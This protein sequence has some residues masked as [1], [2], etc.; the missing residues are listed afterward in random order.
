[1]LRRLVLA[2]A[3]AFLTLASA[4]AQVGGPLC[5]GGGT[6]PD[7]KIQGGSGSPVTVT[8]TGTA[9]TPA[10]GIITVQGNPS[11]TPVPVSGTFSAT[12]GGFDPTAVGTPI[13]A[14]TGGATGTLPSGAVV[15]ATNVG[16]TNGAFCALGASS[17]TSWQYIAPGGGWFAFTVGAATQLTCLTSASTTTINMVGGAGLATG[18]SGGGGS[19]SGAVT[20]NS[21]PSLANGNG[22]VPTQGGTV[23]SA[24]NGMYVNLLQGNAVLSSGNPIFASITNIPAVTQSGGPWTFNQTQLDSVNLGAPSNYGTSPGAV[25]VAGVNAFVTNTPTVTAGLSATLTTP[26]GTLTRPSNTTAYAGTSTTPQLI[27]SSTTA[28]SVVV[29]SF[30]I[31]TSGGAAAIP[32]VTLAT[33][34]TSGWGSVSIIATL[35]TAAPT[36]TNGDGGTYAV[37]TGAAGQRAQYSCTLIQDG[38]GAVCQAAPLNGTAPIV[39]P[40][41]GT[42]IYWD[43][44]IQSSA[45]P[46]SGQTFTLTPQVWN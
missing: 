4:H 18:V 14:T 16:S 35:W 46:A 38:D 26:T 45:T 43:L 25:E 29:P 12:I 9:G 34:K 44:Q 6:S 41:S 23:L 20:L 10:A 15:V 39:A 3:L 2:G 36:Y 5:G 11:G 1:M 22:V 37:A 31:A 27:G 32:L 8:G 7:C 30:A 19:F 33:N 17:S 13:T 40:S 28:G 42:T 21:S 24:T